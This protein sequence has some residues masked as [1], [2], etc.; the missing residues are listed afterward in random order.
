[1]QT[2]KPPRTPKQGKVLTHHGIARADPWYW[3]RDKDDPAVMDYLQAENA[4]TAAVM[5]SA[6]DLQKKL[7]KEMRA[8]IKEDDST[9]PEKE[10]MY[11]YYERYERGAQYRS[12]RRK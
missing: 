1:M 11:F 9:V 10:G 7:Y 3:L 12:N 5:G 8:R 2:P 6:Q 4:Y